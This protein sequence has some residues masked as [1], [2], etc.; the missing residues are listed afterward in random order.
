[1]KRK[2][3]AVLILTALVL[4]G[5]SAQLMFGVSGAIPSDSNQFKFDNV[6]NQLKDGNGVMYGVFGEIAFRKLD[7]CG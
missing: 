6:V 1:M 2:I 5:A 3:F 7:S 4:G